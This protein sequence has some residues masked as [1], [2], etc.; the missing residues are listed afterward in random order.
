MLSS[1]SYYFL[2]L[3]C[4]PSLNHNKK[5]MM[6]KISLIY[7]TSVITSG[8]LSFLSLASVLVVAQE[9]IQEVIGRGNIS[10]EKVG[11]DSASFTA[12]LGLGVLFLIVLG[13]VI[14]LLRHL[15]IVWKEQSSETT[16]LKPLSQSFLSDSGREQQSSFSLADVPFDDDAERYLKEEEKLV[17]KILKSREGQCEQGTLL[18]ITQ[19]SKAYLSTLLSEMETRG[20]I[21]K[22]QKGR[23]N[24]ISLRIR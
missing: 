13:V 3:G 18:V 19:F 5:K 15:L 6:K 9:G 17:Y 1:S 4:L 21:E 22:H 10:V 20:I 14:V 12:V 23:K 8:I 11:G 24:I 2:Y 16:P 7:T